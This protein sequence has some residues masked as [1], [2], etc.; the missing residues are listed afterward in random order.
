MVKKKKDIN[1]KKSFKVSKN[2][3]KKKSIFLIF[4]VLVLIFGFVY[5]FNNFENKNNVV[6]FETNY[7][8]FKVELYPEKAP[9][10]VN[11]FK[12]YVNEGF[13]NGLIFHRVIP[14]F[15]IQGGGFD[16]NMN[17]KETKT[18]IKLESN[19]GLKNQKYTI[20]MARTSIP[21]SATSQF[22]I[23]LNDNNFLNYVDET[24]P[25]YAVFGKVIDGFDVIDKIAN[26]E[27]SNRG[28]YANWP[29]ED[30]IIEKVYFE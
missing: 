9:I 21:D 20:A 18:P 23:N 17:K 10:T 25:G 19:N 28:P 29:R 12:S 2:F 14:N 27:T 22:F 3:K 13:Y 6:V 1:N 26:V 30:V 4:L 8:T 16:V 5:F 7:G 11:N 15:V 24:N